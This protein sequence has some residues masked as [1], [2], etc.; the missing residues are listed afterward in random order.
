MTREELWQIYV[1]KNP[2][3]L[4]ASVTFSA[5]GIRKFFD[6]TFKTALEKGEHDTLEAG[7]ARTPHPSSAMPDFMREF[8]GGKK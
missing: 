4:S 7:A 3:L 1:R 5:N 6:V 8:F 2:A